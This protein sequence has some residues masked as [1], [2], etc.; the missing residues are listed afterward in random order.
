MPRSWDIFCRVIDNYGDAAFAWRIA[1]ALVREHGA[2]VRLV[3]DTLA[4]LHALAPAV[5]PALAHQRVAGVEVLEWPRIQS[6]FEPAEVAVDAFGCGLPDP[7]L[8]ARVRSTRHGLWVTTEYLSAEA[9]VVGAHGRPSPHPATGLA[10]FFFFPGFVQGTGGLPREA[11]YEP[12]RE[13]FAAAG[14]ATAFWS[15]MGFGPSKDALSVSLFGYENARIG[16]LLAHWAGGSD[17]IV[18]AVTASR[19]LGDVARFAGRMAEPGETMRRGALELRFLPFLDQSGYD[20]LLHACAWNF[21]RG[22]DSLV[23]AIWAERP[24]IWQ[25]YPQDD[26][27]HAAKLEA[28]LDWWL[29]EAPPQA[30][31]SARQFSRIWNGTGADGDAGREWPALAQ[32]APA[33]AAAARGRAAAA[34]DVGELVAQLVDFCELRLK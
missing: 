22:E 33:L 24:L 14:G 5:D 15:A 2:T 18:V 9:W 34:R 28:F 30:A 13:A 4:P 17:P 27:A 16:P 12:M 26:L 11:D 7:Y 19:V 10:R 31:A 20:R 32:A 23:R 6:W 8:A 25:A 21:V 29:A 1:S 3:I